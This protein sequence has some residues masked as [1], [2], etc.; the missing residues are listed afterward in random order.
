MSRPRVDHIGIA[1]ESIEKALHFYRD[2]LGLYSGAIVEVPGEKV[3]VAMLAAGEP[4]VEL[5]EATSE[6]SPVARFLSKHGEG[7]H[8]IS[9]RVPDLAQAVERLQAAGARL[10]SG[11]IQTGAE[12]YRYV[13]I[14]PKSAG[15]V[16]IELIETV[17]GG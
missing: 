5:I 14:H 1:V 3:R 9:F 10:V 4:R 12:G 7:M 2:A 16:L 8:H 15:G 13:F 11:K 6:D 17:G